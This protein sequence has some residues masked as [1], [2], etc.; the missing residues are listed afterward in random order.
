MGDL[1]FVPLQSPALRF[2]VAPAQAD[3]EFPDMAGVVVNAK[4]LLDHLGYAL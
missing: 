3:Q 1:F 2:L 4:L